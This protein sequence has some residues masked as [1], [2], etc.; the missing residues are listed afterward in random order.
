MVGESFSQDIEGARRVGMRGVLVRR[1]ES[2]E[3]QDKSVDGVP[4]I[5]SL[6]ELPQLL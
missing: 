3:N 1:S 5:R 6:T 4:I 2:I